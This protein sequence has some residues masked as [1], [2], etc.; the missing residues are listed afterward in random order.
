MSTNGL[1]VHAGSQAINSSK[2]SRVLGC[3]I[4]GSNIEDG[5]ACNIFIL[6]ENFMSTPTADG[7]ILPGITRK[8]VMGLALGLG[9]QKLCPSRM[10]EDQIFR[11]ADN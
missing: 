11:K 5:S 10:N 4:S 7:T 2:S 9:Y 8:D 6:K 1:I 3:L